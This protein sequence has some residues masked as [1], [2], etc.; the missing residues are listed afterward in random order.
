MMYQPGLPVQGGQESRFLGRKF[1]I[2]VRF[3]PDRGRS[4]VFDLLGRISELFAPVPFGCKG[5]P[6][7]AVLCGAEC[8]PSSAPEGFM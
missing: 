8:P 5:N 6:S 3:G 2:F 1:H 7:A 4:N